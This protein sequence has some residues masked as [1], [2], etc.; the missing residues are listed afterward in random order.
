MRG[1]P[2]LVHVETQC[3]A[4][5]RRRTFCTSGPLP[6]PSVLY[7]SMATRGWMPKAAAVSALVM[8]MVARSEAVGLTLTAQSPYTM[9]WGEKGLEGQD[10]G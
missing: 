9:T 6:L 7:D 1:P 3:A 4:T 10:N 8:A 2:L 5:A